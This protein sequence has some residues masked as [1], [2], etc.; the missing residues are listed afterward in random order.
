MTRVVPGRPLIRQRATWKRTSFMNFVLLDAIPGPFGVEDGL[1][2]LLLG[3]RD[4]HEVGADP[5]LADD[6]VGDAVV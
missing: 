6:L 1:L 4:G 3:G 5:A 2:A